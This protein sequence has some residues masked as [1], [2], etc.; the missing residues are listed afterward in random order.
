[1]RNAFL[2]IAALIAAGPATAAGQ[3]PNGQ[4]AV[5][6]VSKLS[7][8]GSMTGFREAARD[9]AAWFRSH[10]IAASQFVVPVLIYNAKV[11]ARVPSAIEVMTVRLGE[12]DV[13][14]AKQD[15]AWKAFVAKYKANSTIVSETRTCFPRNL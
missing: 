1:M 8:G 4:M 2:V 6:R 9:H 14:P 10:G 5:M 12:A 7:P 11:K 3:C 13:P 15:A